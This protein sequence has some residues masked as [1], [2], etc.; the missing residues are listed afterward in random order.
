MEIKK[1]DTGCEIKL[2]ETQIYINPSKIIKD[3]INILSDFTKK[4][5]FDKVFNL[6]GE[7]EVNGL[8]IKGYKNLNNIIYVLSTRETKILFADED[9]KEDIINSIYSDFGEFD[10][11]I[12]QNIK[13]FEK[14][15]DK[16]KFKVVIFLE[17]NPKIKGEKVDKIKLNLKKLEEKTYLLV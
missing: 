13:N 11:A 2:N 15:K 17:K 10:V 7:Y 5:N 3:S 16:L 9:I 12:L 14:L 8:Y 1:I 6:P 4:I